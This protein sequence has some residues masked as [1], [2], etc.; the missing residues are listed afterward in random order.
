[1]P[2]SSIQTT[3]TVHALHAQQI[4]HERMDDAMALSILAPSTGNSVGISTEQR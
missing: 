2:F 1:M 4:T 3:G